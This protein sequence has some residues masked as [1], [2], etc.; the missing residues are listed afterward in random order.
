MLLQDMVRQEKEYAAILQTYRMQRLERTQHPL[1][2]T[3]LSEGARDVFYAA[4]IADL[5]ELSPDKP[6]LCI[7]PDEKEQLKLQTVL[8]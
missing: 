4:M 8:T 2:I 6:L 1:L 5:R 3:G 7:L